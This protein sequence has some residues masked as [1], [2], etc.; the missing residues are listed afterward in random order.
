MTS[1]TAWIR[2]LTAVDTQPWTREEVLGSHCRTAQGMFTEWAAQ[3]GFPDYFGHNWDAFLDCLRGA[4]DDADHELAVVV[5]EA[6]ELL[7][8]EQP[9]VLAILLTVL[10]QAAGGNGTAPGL[11][12]LLDDT[13]DRLSGLAQRM[14]EAGYPVDLGG[15]GDASASH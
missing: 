1:M 9:N 7:A 14:A 2:P 3:L 10:S 11:Q 8:D 6:G 12:L 15:G 5:H 4:V 13:P